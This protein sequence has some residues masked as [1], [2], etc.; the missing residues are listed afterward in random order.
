MRDK[1]VEVDKV[2]NDSNDLKEY[3]TY[4]EY[5]FLICF[6]MYSTISGAF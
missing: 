1:I 4:G 5:Y 2:F 3:Y 6:A